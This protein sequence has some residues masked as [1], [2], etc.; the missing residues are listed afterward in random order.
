MQLK[1]SKTISP[2]WM[3]DLFKRHADKLL[4]FFFQHS[5]F[6]LPYHLLCS[7]W[8]VQILAVSILDTTCWQ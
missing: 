3:E 7:F 4:F 1:A 8:S 2:L 6:Y 5:L